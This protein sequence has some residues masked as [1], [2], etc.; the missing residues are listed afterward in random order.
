MGSKF[1]FFILTSVH[2]VIFFLG[3]FT[4]DALMNAQTLLGTP[5]KVF[6]QDFLQL[7]GNRLS[8][9]VFTTWSDILQ[10]FRITETGSKIKILQR[11][12]PSHHSVSSKHVQEINRSAS[13]QRDASPCLLHTSYAQRNCSKFS[14][15]RDNSSPDV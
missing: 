13:H 1:H 5:A 8:D 11:N 15:S 10:L 7:T 6:F 14:A 2:R 4:C 12:W 3:V 9:T